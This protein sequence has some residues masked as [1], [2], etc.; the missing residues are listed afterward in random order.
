[1]EHS[2]P[3]QIK[4]ATSL[5]TRQLL[6]LLAIALLLN[7][8]RAPKEIVHGQ[9]YAEEATTYLKYAWN[10]NPFAALLAPHMG[11]YSLFNNVIT[12]VAAR[13]LPLSMAAYL[14]VWCALAVRM[15]AAY[16]V[17]TS[18]YLQ[19]FRGRLFTRRAG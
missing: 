14:F 12:V 13:I 1:M 7:L 11:Y 6:S 15:L 4:R 16:L 3:N 18:E 2:H 19:D 10:A 5:P 9:V 8:V 17:I